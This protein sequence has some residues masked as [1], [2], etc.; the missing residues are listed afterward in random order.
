MKTF[1]IGVDVEQELRPGASDYALRKTG[2]EKWR[3]IRL[4]PGS[5]HSREGG[6]KQVFDRENFYHHDP[7]A[8]GSESSSG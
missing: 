1:Q 2:V 4:Q 8:Q 7:D 3:T 5:W 6:E